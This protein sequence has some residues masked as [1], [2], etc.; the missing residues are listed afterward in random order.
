MTGERTGVIDI[1]RLHAAGPGLVQERH[2]WPGSLPVTAGAGRPG[3]R[4]CSWRQDRPPDTTHNPTEVRVEF[5]F[6]V[7][8]AGSGLIGEPQP[9]APVSLGLVD[10]V[11]LAKDVTD[12]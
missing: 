6:G 8:R 9:E 11:G 4:S 1:H 10:P 3:R 12:V 5:D 7:H 2:T